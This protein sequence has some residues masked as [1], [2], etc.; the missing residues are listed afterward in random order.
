MSDAITLDITRI[1]DA[2][3]EVVYEAWADP[4]QIV[5]WCCPDDYH[6]T[7]RQGDHKVGGKYSTGMKGEEDRE[8]IY[9][10][11]YLEMN[12]PEKLVFTH[13]WEDSSD[14]TYPHTTC[15]VELKDLDGKTEMHFT[16]TGFNVEA[17]REGHRSGWTQIFEKLN[18]ELIG[19]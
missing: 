16:Q 1:F 15:V 3:R 14:Y 9:G 4:E 2:P 13:K 17:E 7:F 11:E 5:K 6:V 8:L 10:G 12:P 19:R 18:K